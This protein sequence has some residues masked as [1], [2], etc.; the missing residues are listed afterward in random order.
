MAFKH[1][2]FLDEHPEYL[3]EKGYFSYRHRNVRGTYASLRYYMK[4]LS[5]KNMLKYRKNN[6]SAGKTI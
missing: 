6:K 3:N 4:Y 2:D 5:L 1:K